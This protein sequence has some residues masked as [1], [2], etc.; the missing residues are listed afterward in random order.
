[1]LLGVFNSGIF[2][3]L[4]LYVV[5][6]YVEILLLQELI[7]IIGWDCG[8]ILD[9]KGTVLIIVDIFAVLILVLN[10]SQL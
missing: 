4:P 2:M 7:D 6:K 9:A 8:S 5:V 3:T 1:M 10:E